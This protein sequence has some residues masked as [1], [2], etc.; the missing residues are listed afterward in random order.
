MSVT[1]SPYS[2]IISTQ[3][4][5][6]WLKYRCVSVLAAGHW[7]LRTA[8]ENASQEEKRRWYS[9]Y[10]FHIVY[11]NWTMDFESFQ[12][13]SRPIRTMF[14][15]ISKKVTAMPCVATSKLRN[16]F[17]YYCKKFNEE[18]KMNSEWDYLDEF[19]NTV[20]W[21]ESRKRNN[22]SELNTD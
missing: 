15:I 14:G 7:F 6:T 10:P 17:K 3:Y 2:S 1:F 18:W 16:L 5:K 21:R 20:Y 4:W 12:D 9:V 13:P 8:T 11:C 19:Y 22:T